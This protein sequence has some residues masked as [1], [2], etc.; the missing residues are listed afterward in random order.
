MKSMFVKPR[1]PGLVVVHPDSGQLPDVGDWWPHDQFLMRRLR[2]EDVV[3]AT[4]PKDAPLQSGKS[5]KPSE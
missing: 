5:G 4:P 3:E 1:R 2:D